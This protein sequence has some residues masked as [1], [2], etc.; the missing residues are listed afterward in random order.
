MTT[1]GVSTVEEYKAVLAG[2]DAGR[3]ETQAVC[4]HHLQHALL[5]L[6][7]RDPVRLPPQ[8]LV[9]DQRQQFAA[10]IA[11]LGPPNLSPARGDTVAEPERA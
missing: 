10:R 9:I 7:A 2:V 6:D 11:N 8:R 1:S 3:P 4:R 5:Q